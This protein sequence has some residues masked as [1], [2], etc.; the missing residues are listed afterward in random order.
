MV[1][2]T[3]ITVDDFKDQFPRD[4][5]YLPVWDVANEP[6]NT[7]DRVFHTPTKL[8]YDAVND[9][10]TTEPPSADWVTATDDI[11]NYVQDSDI[12]RAF[13]EAQVNINQALFSSDEQITLVYLYLSAHYLVVDLQNANAGLASSGVFPTNSKT[14]G[15]VSQSFE[16]PQAYKDDPVLSYYAQTGYGNKYLSLVLPRLVGNVGSALGT[17]LP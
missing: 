10:V 12:E 2:L 15:S 3:T 9:G 14:V 4:F 1:D 8:F 6:Y 17:T 5:P 11:D 16:V 13:A 7:G